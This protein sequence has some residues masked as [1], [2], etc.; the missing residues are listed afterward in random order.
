MWSNPHSTRP[1]PAGALLAARHL[2]MPFAPE[3]PEAKTSPSGSGDRNAVPLYAFPNRNVVWHFLKDFPV[4]ASALRAL[5]AYMNVFSIE[6]FIDDIAKA[7]GVD[8]VKFRLNHITDARARDVIVEAA[9][10]FG[11]SSEPMPQGRGRGFAFAQY[12]NL[13]SYFAIACEVEVEHEFRPCKNDQGRGRHG[14]R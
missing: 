2:A 12:K 11:W 5:G 1:G 8:P 10:K 4:R 7:A 14:R 13:A 6:T 3:T 9:Q